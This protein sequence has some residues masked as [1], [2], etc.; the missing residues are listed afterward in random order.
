[1]HLG[2]GLKNMTLQKYIKTEKEMIINV[3]E[4]PH[5]EKLL[6]HFQIKEHLKRKKKKKKFNV[7]AE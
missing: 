6:M 2:P 3:N 1:M 7:N 4:L 5:K